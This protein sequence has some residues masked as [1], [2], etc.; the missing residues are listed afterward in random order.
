MDQQEQS[1]D[2][3]LMIEYT[4]EQ[5]MVIDHLTNYLKGNPQA[6]LTGLANSLYEFETSTSIR[7]YGFSRAI[8]ALRDFARPLQGPETTIELFLTHLDKWHLLNKNH[9]YPVNRKSL[10]GFGIKTAKLLLPVFKQNNLPT[11]DLERYVVM[12]LGEKRL[13]KKEM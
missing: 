13:N 5:Q 6:T 2:T 7:L 8:E 11:I 3:G 9:V 1:K 12:K 10:N 4:E